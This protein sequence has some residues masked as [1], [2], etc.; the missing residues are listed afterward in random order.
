[1]NMR[2]A[3]GSGP[4]RL[5]DLVALSAAAALAV[6]LLAATAA[7]ASSPAPGWE[8]TSRSYPTDLKPGGT[9]MVEVELFNTGAGFSS[10]P[11]TVTDTLPAGLEATKAGMLEG[12]GGITT[13]ANVEGSEQ[14]EEVHE[15][16]EQEGKH[17]VGGQELRVW[18]CSGTT[19]VTCTTVPGF[20][21]VLRPIG[22]GFLSRL[23]IDVRVSQ[24][25]SGTAPNH[26]TATGGGAPAAADSSDPLTFGSATPGFGIVGLHA[27]FANANGTPDTQAGTHPYEATFSFD[28]NAVANGTAGGS[29]RD[30][31]LALP[32]GV[33]GDPHATPQCTRQQFL[34]ALTGGCP[35]STQV[36]IDWGGVGPE[37]EGGF[38]TFAPR[39]G[40][41]NL[42]PPPGVPAEF[43]FTAAGVNIIIEAVVRSG[44][45][46]GITGRVH[47]LGF[48]PASNTLTLWG[49]PAEAVH[50]PQRC[51]IGPQESTHFC[52]FSAGGAALVPL[53]TMPTACEGPLSMGMHVDSWN[54]T[55]IASEN[56]SVVLHNAAGAPIGVSGCEHLG[57]G[58][59]LSVA[60]D[61]SYADTPAGLSV[62]V[63][64]PQESLTD[65]TGLS[66]ADI[67][68]TTVT[69]PEGVAIN[70]GQAA[71]LA[72]CGPAEDGLSTQAE[73]AR[74]EEDNG[75]AH[76]PNASKVGSDEIETPL[77]SK[78]LKGNVY[79]LQSEPPHIKLL[80][81]AEGEGVFLKLVGTVDL[82]EQTGRITTS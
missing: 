72:A 48:D 23:G 6:S 66:T 43:G 34:A 32:P 15:R 51:G 2:L 31:Q 14:N 61:T 38:A 33:I 82:D 21:G 11:V 8:V 37:G 10:G 56:A 26:V 12:F 36:G 29:I 59:Q 9:G 77:L 71:G 27:W 41:Y 79:V 24:S 46:Y 62:Q 69:L 7:R 65:P 5:G 78:N 55:S 68:N 35:P 13:P 60:P 58:P 16:E 18:S 53:L 39:I 47:D 20:E 19:V 25:A 17:V 73:R 1:M 28:L 54:A 76:C 81:A 42:V 49:V 57:F 75:P 44:G 70:P 80:V 22:P 30:V 3:K 63:R 52:G 40:V 45:N 74:G 50:N 4:T 64:M 67:K